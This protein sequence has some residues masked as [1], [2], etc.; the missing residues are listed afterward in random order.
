MTAHFKKAIAIHMLMQDR[1]CIPESININLL[2]KII[3]KVFLE[4]KFKLHV[5]CLLFDILYH[6][7]S[8]DAA[9]FDYVVYCSP[10]YVKMKS[11]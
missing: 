9:L 4:T 7:I 6:S 8:F 2:G 10:H 5:N 1:V 3:C 11:I